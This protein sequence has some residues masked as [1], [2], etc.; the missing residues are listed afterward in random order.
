VADAATL[1]RPYARAAFE[2]AHAAQQLAAWGDLLAKASAVIGDAQVAPLVGNPHVARNELVEFVLDVAGGAS[3]ERARNFLHLL[4]DN[5]RLAVLPEIAAQYAELRAAVENT[6]DVTVTSALPLTTE[7]S[8]K[9]TQALTRRLRRTV[10]LH[11]AVDPSLVGGAIVR[12]GDF[13]VDGSLRGRIERLGNTM[14]G[15]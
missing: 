15:A 10:R 8:D 3:D 11:T 7:Q 14:A 9:L 13:V 5:G 4:A 2:H 6:V 12:A 1:A